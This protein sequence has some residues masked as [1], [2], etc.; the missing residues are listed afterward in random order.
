MRN[1]FVVRLIASI[2]K[3]FRFLSITLCES[4]Y[5]DLVRWTFHLLHGKRIRKNAT[6]EYEC[7]IQCYIVLSVQCSVFSSID[8]RLWIVITRDE[9]LIKIHYL[10]TLCA[11][12]FQRVVF[13]W[14]FVKYKHWIHCVPATDPNKIFNWKLDQLGIYIRGCFHRNRFFRLRNKNLSFEIPTLESQAVCEIQL[15]AFPLPISYQTA[16]SQLFIVS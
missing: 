16:H 3:L 14:S 12:S 8:E 15:L 1:W 7:P 2:T 11:L 5:F 4:I 13:C 10:D 6:L 9:M